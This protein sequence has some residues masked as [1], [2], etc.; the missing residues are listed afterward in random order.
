MVFGSNGAYLE[1]YWYAAILQVD[2][3]DDE[4]VCSRVKIL[5]LIKGKAG[6]LEA[7]LGRIALLTKGQHLCPI[8]I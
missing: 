1:D 2:C 7:K 4:R 3:L 6:K 8:V 5:K